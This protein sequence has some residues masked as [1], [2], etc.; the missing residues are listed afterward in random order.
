[1]HK[2]C[3]KNKENNNKE[4]INIGIPICLILEK[5]NYIICTYN[6]T[7]SDVGKDVQILN[8]GSFGSF[9][10]CNKEIKEK[11]KLVVNRKYI[12]NCLKYKFDKEGIYNVYCIIDD[13]LTNMSCLFATAFA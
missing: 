3:L 11:I 8:N 5:I 13:K 6:I 2:G 7:Q 4:K 9:I 12:T 1:M 10:V